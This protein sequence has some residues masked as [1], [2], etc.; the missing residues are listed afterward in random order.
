VRFYFFNDIGAAKCVLAQAVLDGNAEVYTSTSIR[1]SNT[2]NIDVQQILNNNFNEIIIKIRKNKNSELITGTSYPDNSEIELI[3][4]A[5]S[6]GVSKVTSILDAPLN[7]KERFSTKD[8]GL[9]LPDVL[10]VFNEFTKIKAVQCGIPKG[11]IDVRENPY[12]AF[13]KQWRPNIGD[14]FLPR[15]GLKKERKTVMYAPDPL[16]FTGFDKS[17]GANEFELTEQLILTLANSDLKNLNWL[18]KLHP[19]QTHPE[20]IIKMFQKSNIQIKEVN[21]DDL[22]SAL[23]YTNVILG[24]N[25]NILREAKMLNCEIIRYLPRKFYTDEVLEAEMP[26]P[27]TTASETL[28]E[29]RKLL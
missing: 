2:F 24:M 6:C 22:L 4:Y 8:K 20:R 18:L 29:I 11:I 7:I 17:Y 3:E 9:I 12:L 13:L 25:S 27:K 10:I 15:I 21:D 14:T 1:F 19:K 5:R 16:T 23:F 26:R 28:S